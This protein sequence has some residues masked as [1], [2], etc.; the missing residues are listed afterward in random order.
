MHLFCFPLPFLFRFCSPICLIQE[1]IKLIIIDYYSIL[2]KCC[3]LYHKTSK[4]RPRGSENCAE[5]CFPRVHE[6]FC[7][8]RWTHNERSVSSLAIVQYNR[9]GHLSRFEIQ[10]CE[11]S[12]RRIFGVGIQALKSAQQFFLIKRF[13]KNISDVRKKI[14][15]RLENF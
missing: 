6:F 8:L 5:V 4:Y 7:A 2:N 10:K 11:S 3:A 1:L 9:K 14:I 15:E 13:H 12:W